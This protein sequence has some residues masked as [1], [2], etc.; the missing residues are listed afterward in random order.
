[1]YLD[2]RS[3]E[4]L[5]YIIQNSRTTSKKLQQE[6]S[7]TRRQVGYSFEKINDWLIDQGLEPIEKTQGVY[8]IKSM[9]PG[10]KPIISSEL[11]VNNY[12]PSKEERVEL[13]IL[14]ILSRNEEIS[15]AHLTDKLEVSKN[16]ILADIKEVKKNIDSKNMQLHY[17]REIGYHIKGNEWEKRSL[18]IE[19]VQ[20]ISKNFGGEVLLQ[21][22]MDLSS[23]K[24]QN[25]NT[26]ILK[27]EEEIDSRFIDA[28]LKALSFVF[29]GITRR[30]R[31]NKLI[32]AQ[33]LIDYSE[34][35]DTREFE[36]IN[37]LLTEEEM[38]DFPV[39]EKMYLTLQLLTSK[40]LNVGTLN[41]VEIPKLKNALEEILTNFENKAL[42]YLRDKETLLEKIFRHFKPAYYRIK[43]NL[44]TDYSI[45]DKFTHEFGELHYFVKESISPLEKFLKCTIPEK[46][47]FFLT[48]FIAGH[49]IDYQESSNHHTK[50]KAVVVCPNGLTVSRLMERTLLDLFPEL[51]F[52]SAM[53]V[54]EFN[55]FDQDYDVVFSVVPIDTKKPLFIVNPMIT[56]EEGESLRESVL[57]TGVINISQENKVQH[58]MR[59]IED[60]TTILNEEKLI[61]ELKEAIEIN[62]PTQIDNEEE[63][64]L[65]RK[66]LDDLLPE[67][68]ITIVNSVSGWFEALDVVAD[69]L[70]KNKMITGDYVKEI[71]NNFPT[72]AEYIVLYNRI[73]IPHASIESGAKDLGM[74]LLKIESGLEIWDGSIIYFIVMLSAIDKEQHLN[75]LLQLHELAERE[76]ALAE[77]TELTSAKEMHLYIKEFL[78]KYYLRNYFNTKTKEGTMI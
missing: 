17:S 47:V 62:I 9:L 19:I 11:N 41:E 50:E 71:K 66:N 56:K 12:I 1:M 2:E 73:A 59:I 6:F 35:S 44:T 10:M 78:N 42:V 49:I 20:H 15:L 51:Y 55:K 45:L 39:E 28:D 14:I 61:K 4:L 7:L 22:Y 21:K 69:P 8:Q 76:D 29:E 5:K 60:N 63:N 75:A 68:M 37:T 53:S 54:R 23:E 38:L 27:I 31:Q 16:T 52:H 32:N 24:A 26:Q 18:M 36:A 72:A 43:Y 25:L 67:E 40:S 64:S 65:D 58:F 46:E 57:D 48:L 34:L 3:N 30:I 77:L 70:L 74:S 13:L 33:F